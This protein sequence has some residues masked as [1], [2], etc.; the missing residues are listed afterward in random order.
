MHALS[1]H[2]HKATYMINQTVLASNSTN[3]SS[4]C[5]NQIMLY[6]NKQVKSFILDNQTESIPTYKTQTLHSTEYC[7]TS[8]LPPGIVKPCEMHPY[9][10]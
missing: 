9:N 8:S 6:N 4:L 7:F 2:K 1:A 3:L 5:L 10:F